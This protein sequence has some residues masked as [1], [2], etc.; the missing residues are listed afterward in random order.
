MI[1]SLP[2]QSQ[3]EVLFFRCW[4]RSPL[5]QVSR[6]KGSTVSSIIAGQDVISSQSLSNEEPGDLLANV[7]GGVA[8]GA[9]DDEGF[10]TGRDFEIPIDTLN[11]PNGAPARSRARPTTTIRIACA[12][13]STSA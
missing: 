7:L 10:V 3:R 11:G 13:T 2:E 4:E 5:A 12:G 6:N 1:P 8:G 9:I